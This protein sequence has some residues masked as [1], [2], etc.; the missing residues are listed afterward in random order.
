MVKFIVKSS[1]T[2][3]LPCLFAS[4]EPS[5]SASSASFAASLPSIVGF[6]NFTS[7]IASFSSSFAAS[8]SS[9]TTFDFDSKLATISCFMVCF[10]TALSF[11]ITNYFKCFDSLLIQRDHCFESM[12]CFTIEV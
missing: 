12:D 4:S 6:I 10:T 1:S 8:S 5:Y 9:A 2:K 11:A 3:H 7:S